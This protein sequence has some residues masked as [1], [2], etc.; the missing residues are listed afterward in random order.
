MVVKRAAISQFVINILK[1]AVG[2]LA[3]IY[4]VRE[5]GPGVF[6][7]YALVI[8]LVSWLMFPTVAIRSATSKRISEGYRQNEHYTTGIALE[9]ITI[10]VF[11]CAILF[12]SPL[13]NSYLGF[14]GAIFVVVLLLV[15]SI[16]QYLLDVVRSEGQLFHA[17]LLDGGIQVSRSLL[18]VTFIIVGARIFGLIAGEL[19]AY[20]LG[21]LI[22]FWMVQRTITYPS[23]GDARSLYK[24]GKYS[25]LGGFK[26]VSYAWIDTLILGAFVATSTVG[27]YEVVWRVT[28]L[29]VMLPYALGSVLFPKVSEYST[30]DRLQDAEALVKTAMEYAAALV[31]PG[32]VGAF[33]L[34]NEILAL[35]GEDVIAADYAPILLMVLLIARIAE[36]YEII[37][38]RALGALNF[39]DRTF[40]ANALFLVLNIIL[41]VVL[42]YV[43]GPVGAAVATAL[44]MMASAVLSWWFLPNDFQILPSPRILGGQFGS[45]LLMGI[46][47]TISL[48]FYPPESLSI[49]LLYVTSG[50]LLYTIGLYLLIPEVR[51]HV[52]NHI[53]N[54]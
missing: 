21:T 13:I 38:L 23:W 26:G 25:W 41:N 50:G 42:I 16:A 20:A 40:R 8:A 44:S 27:I 33:L 2:A 54:I 24:Y 35:Y 3:T 29:F 10:V 4:I 15:R 18:Q 6:G 22:L 49:T 36:S 17:S 19:V 1:T 51:S 32:I 37:L 43:F 52:Q 45:A 47:L 12:I 28:G 34:G 48:D 7:Q 30:S 53:I 14:S 11:G 39:P 9:L 31:I 5:A 46:I